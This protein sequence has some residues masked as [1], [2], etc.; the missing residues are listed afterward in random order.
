MSQAARHIIVHAR[1]PKREDE[2]RATRVALR[3]LA[4]ALCVGAAAALWPFWEPLVL[5]AWAA[6]I[7]RPLQQR[8]ARRI[9][10]RRGAAALVTVLLVIVFLT[11]LL[12][13]VLSLSGAALELGQ[14]LVESKSGAEALRLLA[15]DGAQQT[16]DFRKLN[17]DGLIDLLRRHGASALGAAKLLFGAA[18]VIA[19]DVI[20]F[21]SAFY[22]FL[23]EGP[24][25]YTWLLDHLPLRREQVHRL[26]DTFAEVGRGLLIGVGLTALLQGGVA[27]IGYL[28]LE[29]PQPLVL[30][31][32]TVFASLIPS[33]GSGLVW[34][35]VAS[36]LL[37]SGRPGA[38]VAMLVIGSV[39]SLV[40][41]VLHPM[42]AR[43]GHLRMHGLLLFIAMLGGIAVFGPGGLLLGPLCVRMAVEVLA[44]LRQAS[45]SWFPGA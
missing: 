8:I 3:W 25:L 31:L 20:V 30:G 42:L 7:A 35:P 27:T 11:P 23:L 14:R 15:V 41:N 44:M 24:R 33:I 32:I 37:I 43:Y 21:V 45:P 2:A 12:V 36:G 19:L 5:A 34:V 18:T 22:T 40:D 39:V 9:H 10:R 6:I 26:G 4:I 38:A 28:V 13:A 1:R 16:L 29:V 17:L